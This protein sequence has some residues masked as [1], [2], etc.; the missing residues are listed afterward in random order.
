M[1]IQYN[2]KSG[3]I[4]TLFLTPK[5]NGTTVRIQLARIMRIF[6]ILVFVASAI[7]VNL[8]AAE[9]ELAVVSATPSSSNTPREERF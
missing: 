3:P 7:G 4:R 2:P 9:G 5:W 8:A 1:N 6:L